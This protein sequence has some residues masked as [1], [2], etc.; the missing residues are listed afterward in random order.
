MPLRLSGSTARQ[1]YAV[2]VLTADDARWVASYA[3]DPQRVCVWGGWGGV[4]GAPA[5]P[6]KVNLITD[7]VDQPESVCREVVCGQVS[8]EESHSEVA[9]QR[10]AAGEP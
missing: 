6:S 7:S 3:G 2:R 10:T 9:L 8:G 4:Q 1:R 5:L